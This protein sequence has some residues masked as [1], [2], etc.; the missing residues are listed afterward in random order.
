MK[1]LGR[2]WSIVLAVVI[3][4]ISMDAKLK[5][6]DLIQSVVNRMGANSFHLK[7]WTTVL[8]SAL[9]VLAAREDIGAAAISGLFPIL[10]F[11]GL[12][13]YFLHQEKLFRRLYD[14]V[15]MLDAEQID[16]SMDI[17]L[18]EEPQPSFMGTFCSTTL[19][20]FYPAI[21]VGVIAVALLV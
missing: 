2:G 5:H 18:L 20:I 17:N 19:V 8:G 3:G 4:D 15:R 14:H 21:A 10:A 11:W 1:A 6:L 12:D 9:A 7:G 13:A 16:F